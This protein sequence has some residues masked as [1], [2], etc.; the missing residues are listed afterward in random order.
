MRNAASHVA[1]CRAIDRIPDSTTQCTKPSPCQV[2]T[3]L[4]NAAE[5]AEKTE[6]EGI[7]DSRSGFPGREKSMGGVQGRPQ[8]NLPPCDTMGHLRVLRFDNG[9]I[10]VTV[11]FRVL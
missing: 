6:L 5:V 4:A 7:G 8:A 10:L 1:A 3:G 2:N 9:W 11:H